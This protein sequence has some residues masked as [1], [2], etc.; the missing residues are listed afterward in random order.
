MHG[1]RIGEVLHFDF[2][3]VGDNGFLGKE[4]LDGDGLKYTLVI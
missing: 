2:L 1:T 3:Y 4:G